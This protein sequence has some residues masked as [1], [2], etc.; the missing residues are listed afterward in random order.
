MKS[1]DKEIIQ[2]SEAA[3]LKVVEHLRIAMIQS[4]TAIDAL[5]DIEEFESAEKFIRWREQL[6]AINE[7]IERD[8]NKEESVVN[9]IMEE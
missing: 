5:S 7:E 6:S 8:F 9:T 1:T 4:D 3:Q 2:A